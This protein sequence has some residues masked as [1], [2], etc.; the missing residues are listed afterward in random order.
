MTKIQLQN[1][2]YFFIL[3]AFTFPSYGQIC[4]GTPGEVSWSYWRHLPDDL[5]GEMYADEYYPNRPDGSR[6]LYSVQSPTNFDNLFGSV[7]KGFISVPT[8]ENLEFNITG[9]D[10]VLFYL[11]SNESPDNLVM[12]AYI[13]GYTG[14]E[15]HDKYPSQTSRM[16][17][18]TAGQYYYFELHH[19]EGGG[20]DHVT[21]WWKTSFTGLA[22]WSFVPSQYIA[23]VGCLPASCPDRGTPCD[24][25]DTSTTQD[26]EDGHCNCAGTPQTSNTCVGERSR[27]EAYYY[28]GIPGGDLSDLYEDP[29]FPAMPD[30]YELLDMLGIGYRIQADSF[31]T[32]VQGYLTV[33]VTGMYKFNL[34]SNHD[35]IFFLSSNDDPALKQTHQILTTSSTGSVEHNKYIYQSTAPIMMQQGQYYFFEINHKESSWVEHYSIFWKTPFGPA[36]Q[37][38]RIP[39]IYLY[40]YTCEI[41]CISEG[42]P[43][44][45]GDPFTNNDAFN[46]N[47]ECVGTP[48]SGPDCNDPMANYVPYQECGLTDQV[49]N[50]TDA[51]WLSCQPS[52]SPNP[53]HGTRHWIQYDLGMEHKL[54]ASHIWN[55]NVVGGVNEGFQ[56]VTID[57]SMDGV[58]WTSLGNF[59]W[60]LA[61]GDP[62]Y[63]GF[64]GP[65]F[66]GVR[67]RYVLVTSQDNIGSCRGIS[68]MTFSTQECGPV[69]GSCDDGNPD[70]VNDRYDS[71][72]NC[73]GRSTS[74]NDC[75]RDTLTL[76][77]STL[78]LTNYS[79]I[80]FLESSSS[81]NAGSNVQ[82]MANEQVELLPGFEGLTGAILT[83]RIDDCSVTQF[84]QNQNILSRIRSAL[85]Q[86]P[87]VVIPIENT[88]EQ[89]IGF[90][91]DQSVDVQLE[92]V[93]TKGTAIVDLLAYHLQNPGYYT[94]RIRTKKLTDISYEVRLTAGSQHHREALF[95]DPQ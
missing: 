34:T 40:D 75:T 57:H 16:I 1:I 30:R 23:D 9:D 67:A 64:S 17:P 78:T 52:Q 29:N 92:I 37:W 11:S 86:N 74:F 89:W 14:K 65:D 63:P 38:K 91:V 94:K 44:D 35:A 90:Y 12:E 62:D 77:D 72:C 25:G 81:I 51:S 31:G 42:I 68:K 22:N 58:N 27:V 21:L 93:D 54:W 18:L 71:E 8:S 4:V 85:Q 20:G 59:N 95:V 48:C 43:C 83:L 33:P 61:S 60:S 39:S 10:D 41:S 66:G 47:C 55:Y 32:L 56:S 87:L 13:D 79:A 80:R 46:N 6:K 2:V 73:I 49:D 36:N 69:G 24:D 82:F 28:D 5:F 84:T 53:A 45:D 76:G 3:I 15:Q 26:V 19:I 50:R 88:D 7:I 70:T